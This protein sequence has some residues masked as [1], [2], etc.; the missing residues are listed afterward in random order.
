VVLA[1]ALSVSPEVLVADEPVSALDVSIQAQIL[2]LLNNLKSRLNL[3]IIFVTHDL[4]VVNFF[5]DRIA[6]MYMGRLVELGTRGQIMDES[7]H[8]YTRMLLSAAPHG[9]PGESV[10]RPWVRQELD[11]AASMTAGCIFASRC[12]AR[13]ALGNPERCVT[14]RPDEN[15]GPDGRVAACHFQDQV[16]AL[17]LASTTSSAPG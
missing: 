15:P 10:H 14:Q 1:R 17:A 12:W 3:T 4:R 16:P 11:H 13:E 8:P 5:C 6:V 2:N 9:R 7:R